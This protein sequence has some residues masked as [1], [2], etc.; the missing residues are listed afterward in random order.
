MDAVE[1]AED[2][3]AR[4]VAQAAFCS[5]FGNSRR[6]LILLTLG[7]QEKPV[8]EIA[9][10]I[11]A[12][13]QSTSQHLRLMREQGIL[14]ARRD[15]QTIYYRVSSEALAARCPHLYQACREET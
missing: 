1:A 2:R 7:A 5:V 14:A 6:V 3:Q 11:G 9:R 8:S 13:L 15:G 12:S 10:A 4:A